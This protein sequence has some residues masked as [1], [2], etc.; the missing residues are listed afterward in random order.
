M[1]KRNSKDLV[2]A[3]LGHDPARVD[4]MRLYEDLVKIYGCHV[5]ADPIHQFD[6]LS[7]FGLPRRKKVRG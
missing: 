3:Q 7:V 1:P 4:M 2:T 6:P 5:E